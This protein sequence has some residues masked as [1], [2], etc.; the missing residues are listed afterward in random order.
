[1]IQQEWDVEFDR[2]RM[3]LINQHGVPA[4]RAFMRAQVLTQKRHGPRP[5]GVPGHVKLGA[6]LLGGGD[7]V[8]KLKAGWNWLNG[9]KTLIGSILVGVPVIWDA[10]SRMLVA[11]GVE[12]EKVV[13]VGAILL[14]VVGWAH[15]LLKVFGVAK[16]VED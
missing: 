2:I 12:D 10:V 6:R 4:R 8:K 3:A 13:A 1:M 9:K 14:L 16:A 11:G 5:A 7:A 15:K